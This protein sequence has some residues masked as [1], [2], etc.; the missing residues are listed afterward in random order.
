MFYQRSTMAIIALQPQR[1]WR[2]ASAIANEHLLDALVLVRPLPIAKHDHARQ[3][4]P[5]SNVGEV[6]EN[7]RGTVAIVAPV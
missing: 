2:G 3:L 1:Q 4:R 5:C 6:D 7:G